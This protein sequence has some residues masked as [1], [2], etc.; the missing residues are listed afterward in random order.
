MLT[1]YTTVLAMHKDRVP[2]AEDFALLSIFVCRLD[3]P[4]F[5]A[6]R[7]AL[8]RLGVHAG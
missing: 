8:T 5:G 2:H 3:A 6:N 7:R 4:V 1:A